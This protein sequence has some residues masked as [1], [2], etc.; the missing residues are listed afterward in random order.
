MKDEAPFIAEFWIVL[1]MSAA[2]LLFWLGPIFKRNK[3]V[4]PTDDPDRVVTGDFPYLP[5][6]LRSTQ[7]S[8]VIRIDRRRA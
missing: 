2:G 6:P 5:E 1:V 7:E 8:N 4:V 3:T